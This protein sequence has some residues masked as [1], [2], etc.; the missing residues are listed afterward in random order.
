[1][2]KKFDYFTALE[3][4]GDFAV[5]EAVLLNEIFDQFDQTKMPVWLQQMHEL[6]N[7]ADMKIHEVYTNL[8]TEFITPIDRE[9][10]LAT[11]QRLDDIVDSIED[12]LL[13]MHM[14]NV[15]QI[16]EPAVSFARLILSA[17]T[18]L[19]KLL[20][21]FKTF[22]KSNNKVREYIVEVNDIEEE[23]DRLYAE[24]MNSLYRDHT[25]EPLYVIIWSNLFGQMELAIDNCEMVADGLDTIILKNT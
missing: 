1:M 18:A 6:E 20:T 11:G 15:Q 10:I 17:S 21:E 9:D 5:Q 23:A 24:T 14:F 25:D 7:S 22:K 12:V 13:K 19:V 3:A 4:Q 16:P 8:A 2:A